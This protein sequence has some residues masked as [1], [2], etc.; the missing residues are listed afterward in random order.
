VAAPAH[1]SLTPVIA[2]CLTVL[3]GCF[4]AW[5]FW[6]I[7]SLNRHVSDLEGQVVQLSTRV[8]YYQE[9]TTEINVRLAKEGF[10]KVVLP[11][12]LPCPQPSPSPSAPG[13]LSP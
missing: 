12:P 8:C 1:K 3:I 4:F 11:E 2:V 10:P 5:Q 13:S 9:I 7:W 6:L